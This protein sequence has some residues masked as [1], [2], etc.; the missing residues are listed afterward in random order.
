MPKTHTVDF[1]SAQDIAEGRILE[2]PEYSQIWETVFW[3]LTTEHS[4]KADP[5]LPLLKQQ[6]GAQSGIIDL[7]FWHWHVSVN[8]DERWNQ[9]IP[10]HHYRVRYKGDEVA[11]MS[12]YFLVRTCPFCRLGDPWSRGQYRPEGLYLWAHCPRNPRTGGAT[13]HDFP[14]VLPAHPCRG[15]AY[16]G[17]LL[18]TCRQL[19]WFGSGLLLGSQGLEPWEVFQRDCAEELAK[20]ENMNK[21]AVDY[22]TPDHIEN[23]QLAGA[24]AMAEGVT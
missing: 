9:G 23:A 15:P 2:D 24:P 5:T 21:L 4:I 6:E 1:V 18:N 14:A 10:P 20:R 11:V 7:R 22:S 19:D 17:R 16:D 8:W 12:P 13:P 3:L